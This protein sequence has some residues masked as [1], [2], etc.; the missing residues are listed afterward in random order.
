MN[1]EISDEKMEQMVLSAIQKDVHERVQKVING[2]LSLLSEQ[3]LEDMAYHCI[4]SLVN[5]SV[6][7]KALSIIDKKELM[8]SI[9]ESLTERIMNSLEGY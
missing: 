4:K 3:N 5:K 9:A 7:D 8:N 1:Y 6:I 2:N